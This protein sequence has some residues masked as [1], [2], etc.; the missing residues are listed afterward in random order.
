MP[1]VPTIAEAGF[2]VPSLVFWGGYAVRPETPKAAAEVMRQAV[3]QAAVASKVKESLASFSIYPEVSRDSAS[4]K[5]LIKDDLVW[6]QDAAV[7]LD[8]SAN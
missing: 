4:F 3:A 8:T 1:D 5:Q 2:N 7:G 6:M